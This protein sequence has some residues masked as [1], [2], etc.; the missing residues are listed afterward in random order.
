MALVETFATSNKN[1]Q[2]LTKFFKLIT[3]IYMC[4][5]C[6]T[7]EHESAINR[8]SIISYIIFFNMLYLLCYIVLICPFGTSERILKIHL[9]T[10]Q[11]N[12]EILR[13]Q[14]IYNDNYVSI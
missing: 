3:T 5:E 7:L 13:L 9:G 4:K 11:E 8:N 10:F 12:F 14:E 1:V 6:L 2:Y